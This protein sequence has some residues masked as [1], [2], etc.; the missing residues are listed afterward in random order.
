MHLHLS[1]NDVTI[2]PQTTS[3][4]VQEDTGFEENVL[5]VGYPDIPPQQQKEKPITEKSAHPHH[6]IKTPHF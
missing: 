1:E 3:S 4:N 5:V 2:P 6:K